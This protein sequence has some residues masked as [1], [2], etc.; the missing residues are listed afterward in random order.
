MSAGPH[1]T[2]N[3]VIETPASSETAVHEG[4]SAMAPHDPTGTQNQQ[5]QIGQTKSQPGSAEAAAE[6]L[7][8][9]RMEDETKSNASVLV[10]IFVGK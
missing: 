10:H 9:E 5:S 8:E 2:T 3:P 7:H 6:K 1:T 4:K